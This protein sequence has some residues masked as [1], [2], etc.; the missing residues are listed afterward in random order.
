M[1]HSESLLLNLTVG[2]SAAL[3][4]GGLAMRFRLSPI[5]GYLVAGI[6]CG[7]STAGFV[8]NPGMAEELADIGVV[9]LMF[10]GGLHFNFHELFKVR[11]VALPGAVVQS[12]LTTMVVTAA[13]HLMG[14]GWLQGIIVGMAF[15]VASTA[16]LARMLT[17]HHQLSTPGGHLVMGWTVVEDIFTV[18]VL[19]ILPMLAAP[20]SESGGGFMLAKELLKAAGKLGLF[21]A[22][23]VFLGTRLVPWILDRLANRREMFN[24]AIPVIALGIAWAST[25]LFNVSLALGSFVA[26][27]L[28]AQSLQKSRIEATLEPLRDTFA[29]LFFLSIGTLLDPYYV[30]AHPVG[31]IFALGVILLIKPLVALILMR[32]LRQPLHT[33]LVVAIGIGQIGEFSFI[34]IH[35]ASI[36]NLLPVDSGHLLVAAAIIS[37]ALNPLLFSR[38]TQIERQLRK[39]SWLR[40]D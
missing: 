32:I 39:L 25:E 21:I 14:L 12:V 20:G 22:L 2:L 29:A 4:C 40:N 34:L 6:L 13:S 15:S 18:I 3:L 7:P 30:L 19:V 5:V 24:L 8:I 35:Q 37:I 9:L 31:L 10:G 23:V 38:L 17:D 11:R 36:L 28:A 16:V 33:I 26:G 27:V 1:H